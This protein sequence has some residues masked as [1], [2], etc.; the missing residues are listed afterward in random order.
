MLAVCCC[1]VVGVVVLTLTA[2]GV[3][4]IGLRR[5]TAP[6]TTLH[7]LTLFPLRTC[8]L[9]DRR[10]VG[11]ER[12][13]GR[14]KGREKEIG[15]DRKGEGQRERGKQV[16]REGGR[17]VETG[18]EGGRERGRDREKGRERVKGVPHVA[19]RMK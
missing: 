6:L 5:R 8:Y 18:R 19:T 14:Q 9:G 10:G 4:A 15:I 12:D 2:R 1:T 17:G 16:E 13:K 3:A 11:R 7:L